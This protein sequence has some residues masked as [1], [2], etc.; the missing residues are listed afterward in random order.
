MSTPAV[1]VVMAVYNGERWLAETLASL[2]GQTFGDFEVVAIDDGST[3]GSAAI[4]AEAAARDARYRVITQANRGLVASLNRGLAEARAPLVARLDA[5]DIAEPE[6]FARQ[7]AF[8]HVHPEVAVLGSAIRIIGEDGV[9]GRLQSYPCGPAEVAAGMLHRCA[10]AHPAVMM[11]R[12]AVLAIG[13]YREAFRHAEDYDLWLRLGERHALDNLPEALLRYRQHVGSVSFRH[14]QQQALA[15]FVARLCACARRSGKPDP[16]HGFNQPMEPGI[17]KE[18]R[19]EP[20]QEAEFRLESLKAALWPAGQDN[21]DGWLEENME[22]A[23]GLRS[24]LHSGSFVRRCVIPYVRRCHRQG[25]AEIARRWT[26]RAFA[27]APLS[28]AWGLLTSARRGA[29]A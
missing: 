14:R 23:W 7:V 10:F 18:L 11:R 20:A 9:F 19:L 16:L 24:H 29:R 6:R 4:L 8:L 28:A 15:A 12:D 26:R 5:D 1:S 27:L 25:R 17:L 13:G 3:D 21:D 2:A 22:L